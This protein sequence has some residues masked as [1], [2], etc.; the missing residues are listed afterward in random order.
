MY[1]LSLLM[2]HNL[3]QSSK[4][5]VPTTLHITLRL[6]TLYW[7]LGHVMFNGYS[8]SI[9][10]SDSSAQET[11]EINENWKRMADITMHMYIKLTFK[12]EVLNAL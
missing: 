5:L 3:A 6:R 8:S 10:P 12:S 9:Y 11:N 2:N 1:S 7:D 4:N